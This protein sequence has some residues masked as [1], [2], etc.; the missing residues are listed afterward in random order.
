LVNEGSVTTHQ[1]ADMLDL[2]PEWY[3]PE[4]FKSVTSASRSNCTIPCNSGMRNVF[5]AL[6]EKIN[7]FKGLL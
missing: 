2:F 7:K 1:L 5:V 3:T 4:E 6:Q